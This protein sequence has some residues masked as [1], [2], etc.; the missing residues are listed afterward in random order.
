MKPDIMYTYKMGYW[1]EKKEK[2]KRKYPFI[3]EEDLHFRDGKE[4]VM[5]EILAYKLKTTEME[6]ITILENL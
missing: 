1:N 4:K 3:S 5:I 2:L 6:L